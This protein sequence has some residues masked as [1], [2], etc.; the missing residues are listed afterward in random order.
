M[1]RK[2]DSGSDNEEKVQKHLMKR[3][4]LPTFEGSDPMGWIARA[5]K[6]FA[7]QSISSKEKLRLTFI[8]ME[9]STSHWFSFCKKKTKNPSWEGFTEALNKRFRCKERSIVFEKLTT[10]T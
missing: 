2:E 8:S 7:I 5:K 6:F 9:G 1:I 3:V 10:L 4:E